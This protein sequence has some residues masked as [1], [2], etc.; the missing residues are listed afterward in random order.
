MTIELGHEAI[1][2]MLKALG[3]EKVED[4]RSAVLTMHIDDVVTLRVNRFVDS[5]RLEALV[6]NYYLVRREPKKG[7]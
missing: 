6:E 5:R 3:L 4:V 7:Q 2:K 1:P